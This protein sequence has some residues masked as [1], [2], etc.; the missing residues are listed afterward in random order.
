MMRHLEVPMFVLI[1]MAMAG[2]LTTGVALAPQGLLVALL[3]AP[4]G[5]S[6]CAALAALLLMR[7]R[8][9][10]WRRDADLDAQ[11]DAMVASLRAVAAQA[12]GPGE[13]EAHPN[14]GSRAA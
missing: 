11:V 13:R 12:N 2:G 14:S 7:R 3:G 1:A 10:D 5:G 8:D 9:E 6:L 4:L